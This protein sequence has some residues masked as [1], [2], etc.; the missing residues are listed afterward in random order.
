M[1]STTL[2]RRL[3]HLIQR[4]PRLFAL[5]YY[6]YRFLQPKYTLGVI[7]IVFNEDGQFLI[8]EHVFHP[9]HPWGIPGGWIGRDEDPAVAVKRELQ[10]ELSLEV[11]V[12]H[13][14]LVEKTQHNHIDTA[15]LCRPLG[16]VGKLSYELLS[17][18]WTTVE[19]APTLYN[20]HVRAVA[21]AAHILQQN[22]HNQ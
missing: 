16:A 11:E 15:Y 4:V 12:T 9:K 18:R 5:V 17:Y 20:F 21:K 22:Q 6:V 7:G 3:L 19:E 2:R 8:V 10:E 13:L 14:L 1:P